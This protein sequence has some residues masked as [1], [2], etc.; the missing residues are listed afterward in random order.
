MIELAN[1]G[2]FVSAFELGRAIAGQSDKHQAILQDESWSLGHVRR[3]L[4]APPLTQDEINSARAQA[5]FDQ[6]KQKVQTLIKQ[7]N[8]CDLLVAVLQQKESEFTQILT[9]LTPLAKQLNKP[10][11]F[12]GS[13]LPPST[14][15]QDAKLKIL[16]LIEQGRQLC[17]AYPDFA[18][19]EEHKLLGR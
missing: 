18:N 2:D 19:F 7:L 1:R 12:L 10:R 3:Y 17:P 16:N 14:E 13:I 15:I 6:A 8:E 4:G 5:L 11:D 9:D